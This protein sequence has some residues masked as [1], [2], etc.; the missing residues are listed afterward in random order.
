MSYNTHNKSKTVEYKAWRNMH[1]RCY[2]VNYTNFKHWGG[3]G[4]TVCDRWKGRGNFE[5]FLEDIGERPSPKHTL[6][7]VDNNG[8]YEPSNCKWVSY[9]QQLINRRVKPNNSSGLVG[10]SWHKGGKKWEA[11]FR[12]EYLGLYRTKQ[13]AHSI[14]KAAKVAYSGIC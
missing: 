3:R 11:Q 10:V 6:D 5:N 2:N 14:Y 12:G 4:I 9:S 1:S 7:R 8:N 13:E